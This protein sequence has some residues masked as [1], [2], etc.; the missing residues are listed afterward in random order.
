MLTL[1]LLER[2]DGNCLVAEPFQKCVLLFATVGAV[3]S[4]PGPQ[5]SFVSL[6]SVSRFICSSCESAHM[7]AFLSLRPVI[8]L[9]TQQSWS[10]EIWSV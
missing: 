10:Y 9:A 4:A 5:W 6:F 3:Y 8:Q 2:T 7:C 1:T